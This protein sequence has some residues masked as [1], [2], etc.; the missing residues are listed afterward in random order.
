[1]RIEDVDGELVA[2]AKAAKAAAAAPRREV[3]RAEREA[4]DGD[5][6]FGDEDPEPEPAVAS[7]SEAVAEA[8]P[9]EMVFEDD[10]EDL[11]LDF[12]ERTASDEDVEDSAED[13][14]SL[15][16]DEPSEREERPRTGSRGSEDED[17]VEDDFIATLAPWVQYSSA[18]PGG[19]ELILNARY[20]PFFRGYIDHSDQNSVDQAGDLA[21]TFQRK[22]PMCRCQRKRPV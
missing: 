17:D 10:S 2:A 1:M 6:L 11:D 18:P 14:L 21:L 5:D 22:Q 9:E 15:D 8:E 19:A 4:E 16:F 12:G 3:V 7:A 13:E 20:S